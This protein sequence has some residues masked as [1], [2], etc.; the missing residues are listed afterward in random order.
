MNLWSL[1]WTFVEPAEKPYSDTVICP[2]RNRAAPHSNS[3]AR[4]YHDCASVLQELHWLPVAERIDLKI[5]LLAFKSIN[6]MAL[7]VTILI[8][9]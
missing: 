2:D 1:S 7:L 3:E 4:P 6:G 9:C 8:S 5:L